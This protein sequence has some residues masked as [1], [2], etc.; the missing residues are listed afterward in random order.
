MVMFS[1][2][3]TKNAIMHLKTKHN[4]G[5]EGIIATGTTPAQQTIQAAFGQSMLRILFN[6]NIFKKLLL[7]WIVE[8]VKTIEQMLAALCEE[9]LV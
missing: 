7:L 4:I 5:P 9:D 6:E 1:M 2:K 3:T 8:D